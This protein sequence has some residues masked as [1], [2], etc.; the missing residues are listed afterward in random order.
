M[1]L[2]LLLQHGLRAEQ[3][4]DDHSIR[5]GVPTGRAWPPEGRR[6]YGDRRRHSPRARLLGVYA[7]LFLPTKVSRNRVA[8]VRESTV[9]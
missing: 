8:R 9:D 6:R 4:F 2:V 3:R 7:L 1:L 5:F